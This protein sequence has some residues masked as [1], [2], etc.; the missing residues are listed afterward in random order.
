MLFGND[1]HWNPVHELCSNADER[2]Y[3]SY[4]GG[5]KLGQFKGTLHE[6]N[7]HNSNNSVSTTEYDCY[8]TVRVYIM[9]ENHKSWEESP[10]KGL[11]RGRITNIIAKY[12]AERLKM[13][14]TWKKCMLDGNWMSIAIAQNDWFHFHVD[15]FS[16]SD[17]E[18][19]Q[20]LTLTLS[21]CGGKR[22]KLTKLAS[23]VFAFATPTNDI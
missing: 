11:K 14:H 19:L 12:E 10:S 13:E 8:W 6:L 22:A 18:F 16:N 23:C 21:L 4:M 3:I 5:A 9:L 20:L 17:F 15:F 1:K 2:E 7:T